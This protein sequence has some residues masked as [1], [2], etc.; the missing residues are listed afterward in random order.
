M[1]EFSGIQGGADLRVAIVA[2]RFNETLVDKLISGALETFESRGVKSEDITL[3][4]VPGSYELPMA[5][6]LLVEDGVVH[7]IAALG[8]VIRGDTYHF[9]LVCDGANEGLMRV[10]LDAGIPI[11]NGIIAA[12]NMDQAVARVGGAMGNKGSEAAL[13][14]IEMISLKNSMKQGGR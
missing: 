9:E 2:A 3:V 14:L 8:V 13:A 5:C 11:T 1:R 7:G 4:R 6:R 12:E 10:S